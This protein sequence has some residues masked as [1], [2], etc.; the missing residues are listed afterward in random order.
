MIATDATIMGGYTMTMERARAI[1][2]SFAA[3]YDMI[4]FSTGIEEDISYLRDGLVTQARVDKAVTRILA[5]K[6]KVCAGP[7]GT[8][9][10][11]AVAEG[12]RRTRRL[13]GEGQDGAAPCLAGNFP[14]IGLLTK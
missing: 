7:V 3:G 14:Q 12:V 11:Q 5:L 8:C 10:R 2:T 1:P 9:P 13:P 6:A 4:V